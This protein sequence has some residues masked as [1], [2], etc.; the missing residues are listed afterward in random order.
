MVILEVGGETVKA[1]AI[2]LL[3]GAYVSGFDEE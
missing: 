3:P 2:D 1:R